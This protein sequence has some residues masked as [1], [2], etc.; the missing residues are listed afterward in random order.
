MKRYLAALMALFTLKLAVAQQGPAANRVTAKWAP[1][2]LVTGSISLNGEYNLGKRSMTL[3]IGI[4]ISSHH[5]IRVQN[6]ETDL[7]LKSFT[8][9][10]G[11]RFYLSH[12]PLEGFYLEPFIQYVNNKADGI[13]SGDLGGR[14]ITIN[15]N[16]RFS[17]GGM[18]GQAGIQ[19]LIRKKVVLDLFLLG[20]VLNYARNDFLAIEVQNGFSWTQEEA[21][22]A[23]KRINE[24]IN[25]S[26]F[27]RNHTTINID[28]DARTARARFKG[29]LP[30]VRTGVS[31]GVAL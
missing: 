15:F 18:G 26:P 30:G 11:Y 1:L 10:A 9:L 16:N 13:E 19:Y 21:E 17:G 5:N 4:P 7:R 12:Q 29:F 22:D 27:L 20:P 23:T 31:I 8:L 3:R 14:G 24:F 6:N 2:S 25:K 28:A